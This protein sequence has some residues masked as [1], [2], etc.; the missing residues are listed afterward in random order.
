MQPLLQEELNYVMHD[1]V[2]ASK[3]PAGP[4]VYDRG[5]AIAK[6]Q[7]RMTSSA[8]INFVRSLEAGAIFFSGTVQGFR[9]E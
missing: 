4:D 5:H 2:T 1:A 8:N 3:V 9:V 7:E 6:K